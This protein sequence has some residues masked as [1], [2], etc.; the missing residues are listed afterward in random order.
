MRFCR[1]VLAAV[2][3]SVG[4]AASACTGNAAGQTNK[5]AGT[6][7]DA[8]TVGAD[9]ALDATRV[10]AGDVAERSKAIALEAGAAMNDGWI[11]TKLKA[12][13]ADETVLTGSDIHVDTSDHV[14]TLKGDVPSEVAKARA[15]EIARGT[16][17]VT[18]VVNLLRASRS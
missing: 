9:K 13:F 17:G 15:L 7:L 10:V 11:T 14:V 3:V 5:D 6:T 16:E 1:Y 4:F 2:V 8:T 12:K 18:S